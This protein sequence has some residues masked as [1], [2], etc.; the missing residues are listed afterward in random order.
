M[1]RGKQMAVGSE[2]KAP[3]GYWYVKVQLADGSTAWRLKHHIAMEKHLGRPLRENERVSFVTG[4]K[5]D[6]SEEN[7]RVTIKGK[8]SNTR[9][10]AQL[11]ARIAELIA[12]RDALMEEEEKV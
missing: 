11:D 9:R 8:T 5:A 12:E 4:N 6:F 10:I 1:A 2:R 7:L 3:N